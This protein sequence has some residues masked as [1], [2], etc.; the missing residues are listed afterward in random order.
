MFQAEL[1]N[2][3]MN[4][5]EEEL[6]HLGQQHDELLGVIRALE[7][8]KENV[9]P[10]TEALVSLAPGIFARGTVRDTSELFVNV[11]TGIFTKKRPGEVV[12]ALQE[13]L[14]QMETYEQEL[15]KRFDESLKQ[16]QKIEERVKP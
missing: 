2:E 14:S 4:R 8:F 1:L 3:Q 13:Q 16:L 7:T 9:T 15:R 5:I 12:G 6:Q 10:G 11:G